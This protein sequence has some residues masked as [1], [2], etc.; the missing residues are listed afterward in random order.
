LLGRDL[1]EAGGTQTFFARAKVLKEAKALENEAE[2]TR[3][4]PLYTA[5]ACNAARWSRER[6][7]PGQR[8]DPPLAQRLGPFFD[9]HAPRVLHRPRDPNPMAH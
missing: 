8:Q 2:N 3:L 6:Q 7:I 1:F 5:N 4:A 9:A